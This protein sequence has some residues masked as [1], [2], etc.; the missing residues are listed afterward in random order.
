MTKVCY[1]K[2]D[3]FER[4]EQISQYIDCLRNKRLPLKFA[5]IGKTAHTHDKLVRSNEYKLSD[6][7]GRLIRDKLAIAQISNQ[8]NPEGFNLIDIGAGNGV[9][10]TNI[11]SSILVKNIAVNY[12]AL[13]YSDEL[14]KIAKRNLLESFP[15]LEIQ[16]ALIDFE[17]RQFQDELDNIHFYSTFEKIYLFLGT[18]LGNPFDRMR[19]LENIRNSIN[20][21]EKLLIGVE[22]YDENKIDDVLSHYCNTPFYNAVFNPLTFAGLS[23]ED[24][25]LEV[26]FN[27]GTR[28]V[29]VHFIINEK[30]SVI[31]NENAVI[32]FNQY[33]DLLIFISHRFT[34]AELLSDLGNLDF[35]VSSILLDD[36]SNYA[37]SIC[38]GS[39]PRVK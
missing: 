8:I 35:S 3:E 11:I 28:N 1:L 14:L 31:H 39:N 19:T 16:T 21:G 2:A 18:T 36:E 17:Q 23:P 34:K 30:I 10:A 38:S 24:G 7:E 20:N 27:K 4:L 29:E 25:K 26:V 12:I 33:D 15:T 32:E 5:Y 6:N 9:K 22:L 37:L 13:D